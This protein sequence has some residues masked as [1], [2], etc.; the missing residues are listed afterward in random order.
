MTAASGAA[1]L[2]ED[3]TAS[4]VLTLVVAGGL[5]E[6]LA[7]GAAQGWWLRRRWPR[8]RLGGY[9]A[10]TV[11]VAGLGWAAGSA[12][13]VLAGGDGGG[14]GP[15]IALVLLGAAAIGL[16]M[17]PVLGTGQA[18]AMRGAVPHPY[19]WVVANTAAWPLAMVLIFLGATGA[20]PD[21][22]MPTLLLAG[23]ATGL[24]A[25]SALGVVTGLWLPSLDGPL[26]VAPGPPGDLLRRAAEGNGGAPVGVDP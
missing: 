23:A 25:G 16:V 24:A 2:G 4:V 15:S 17:G 18:V 8:L 1:R 19:K 13:G 6:G 26:G 22:S 20:W 5:V 21:W 10:A 11:V 3:R 12:P 9:L 14:A 7:L